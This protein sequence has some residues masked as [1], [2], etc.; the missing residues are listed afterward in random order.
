MT[1]EDDPAD[2][3]RDG[4]RM[5]V[6]G[7][8]QL[9]LDDL[10]AT[11][12]LGRA[13]GAALR[14]GDVVVLAGELGA[15]KTALTKSIA[16]GMGITAT[17]T[18]PTFVISRVH[19]GPAVTL[20]HVDAYRLGGAVELEDLDLDTDLTQAAVVVEWGTG[21]A[22]RF[23]EHPLTIT[24]HRRSDDVRDCTVSGAAARW[25]ALLTALRQVA[26]RG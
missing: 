23:A 21:V 8:V 16:L 11:D 6:A 7:D 15:G 18:S 25:S 9:Q 17:V 13:V 19:P 4:T 3:R 2:D 10:A 22:E 5:T 12:R 24:L 14:A 26:P 1:R 20:V